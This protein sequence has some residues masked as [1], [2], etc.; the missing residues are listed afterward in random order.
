MPGPDAAV[1][2]ASGN[3]D[4]LSWEGYDIPDQLKAWREANGVEVK[5]TYIANHDEIQAKLLAGGGGQGYDIIT[6]YQ[7]YR[8]LYSDLDILEP[9]DPD[10]MP[11]LANLF[12]YFASGDKEFWVLA[13]GTRVG[14]PWTWGSIGITY[15]ASVVTTEP[16]S[17]YEL[18]EPKWKGK[19]GLPDDPTGSL[20]LAAHVLGKDPAALPKGELSEVEDLLRQIIAQA[21]GIAPSFGDLSTQIVSGDVAITWQGWAA[22]NSFAAAAGKNDVKTVVPKEGAFSFC[23]AYA[24]PKGADNADTA[25][26]WMNEVLDPAVN[27]AAAVYLVGAVVVEGAAEQLDET[28]RA[29]YPYEDLE[30]LLERAPF[31]GNPPRESAEFVTFDEWQ[32]K[33]QELKAG[34]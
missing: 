32:A 31:Y 28:T 9:L 34:A 7:G 1:P 18:L 24:I 23:D 6:Y 29:L 5:P 14:V 12:P 17:W 25:Y 8:S 27:A 30:G 3:V 19:V 20:A 11:N 13:D 2:T 10:K 4:F 22:I 21:K 26:A 33:W 16:T 15:D